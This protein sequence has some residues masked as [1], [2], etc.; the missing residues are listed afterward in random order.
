MLP[1]PHDPGL[2]YSSRW[3][4]DELRVGGQME[5]RTNMSFSYHHF[6]L[7]RWYRERHMWT[8][9]TSRANPAIQATVL[10]RVARTEFMKFVFLI[11]KFVGST[12]RC[13]GSWLF[14]SHDI[15]WF[16]RQVDDVIFDSGPVSG[17][18]V[19]GSVFLQLITRGMMPKINWQICALI[20]ETQSDPCGGVDWFWDPGPAVWHGNYSSPWRIGLQACHNP[21]PSFLLLLIILHYIKDTVLLDN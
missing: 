14:F 5:S 11:T 16:Q 12:L 18:A 9:L 6:G 1:I 19:K 17:F 21:G 8:R 2:P 3:L 13:L 4:E 10:H 15:I 7:M 20:A